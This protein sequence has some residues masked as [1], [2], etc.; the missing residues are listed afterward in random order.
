MNKNQA[1]FSKK[2]K[3]A[4][5]NVGTEYKSYTFRQKISPNPE[6]WGLGLLGI[7]YI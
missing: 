3:K 5:E 7:R 6:R 2:E 1:K 4:H